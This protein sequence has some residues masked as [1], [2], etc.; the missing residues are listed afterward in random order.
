[1]KGI[2]PLHVYDKKRQRFVPVPAEHDQKNNR[3]VAKRN[4][5]SI[6]ALLV[7]T[8]P[9]EVTSIKASPSPFNPRIEV[10][11]FLLVAT[12]PSSFNVLI[13][14]KSGIVREL[15]TKPSHTG[16]ATVLWDGRDKD[17]RV[18]PDGEYTF[19]AKA[20]DMSG[21]ESSSVSGKVFVLMGQ[22]GSIKGRVRVVNQRDYSSVKVSVLGT[23]LEKETNSSGQFEIKGVPPGLHEAIAQRK[24]YFPEF[25]SNLSVSAGAVTS[26]PT[27]E[28]T[29]TA[30]T[31]GHV[32][33]AYVTPDDD[34]LDDE[35]VYN[36]KSDRAITLSAIIKDCTGSVVAKPW[37][38]RSVKPGEHNV[39]WDCRTF[40]GVVETNGRHEFTLLAKVGSSQ[41]LQS[42]ESFVVDEG[43][44]RSLF[45]TPKIISPNGDG[46]DDVT[47]IVYTVTSTAEVKLE[48]IDGSGSPL[49]QLVKNEK[50]E[51][52]DYSV[53]WQGDDF[54]GNTLAD[55]TYNVVLS[56]RYPDGH[57][58]KEFIKTV[59]IDSVVPEVRDLRPM[60]GTTLTTGMPEISARLVASPGDVPQGNVKIKVDEHTVLPDEYSIESGLIRYRPK[61]SLGSGTHIAIVY[62]RD[63]AGN[64]APP[65]A[66]SFKVEF[67]KT[68][69]DSVAPKVIFAKPDLDGLVYRNDPS[70]EL[71]IFDEQSGVDKDTIELYIDGER[72]A[73]SVV[74]YIPGK[75]GKAWD[76]WQYEKM[77]VLFDPLQGRIRYNS[78]HELKRRTELEGTHTWRF[79]IKDRAGNTSKE[80]HGRFKLKLD[81]EPP[82][83]EILLPRKVETIL[84]P[85]FSWELK[86]EGP[87]G[88]DPFNALLALDGRLIEKFTAIANYKISKELIG[89]TKEFRINNR[90][91]ELPGDNKEMRFTAEVGRD[92]VSLSTSLRSNDGKLVQTDIKEKYAVLDNRLKSV[93]TASCPNKGA[94]FT[95]S[96][97]KENLSIEKRFDEEEKKRC[98]LL[99]N[100]RL[101]SNKELYIEAFDEDGSLISK[102]E[103][104]FV[105]S[106]KLE[107]DLTNDEEHVIALAV[108]DRAGN[109]SDVFKKYFVTK[110]DEQRPTI[111][112]LSPR[113][114]QVV[115]EAPVIRAQFYDDGESGVD[116]DG[117]IL[118]LDGRRMTPV[119]DIDKG[120][121]TRE[122]GA[123]TVGE[124]I[125]T[126]TICDRA[127]N[128]TKKSATFYHSTDMA[129]PTVLTFTPPH[130]STISGSM[131]RISATVEDRGTGVDPSSIIVSLDG[132]ILAKERI[133]FD[134]K[135][136]HLSVNAPIKKKTGDK[137]IIGLALRD[138]GGN[139]LKDRAISVFT[140]MRGGGAQ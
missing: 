42:S 71:T 73:N 69:R 40:D 26:L 70:F 25:W 76:M 57:Q 112:Y 83:A 3:L 15:K 85:T 137:H 30:L 72:V 63:V 44:A 78:L 7:D 86:D 133:V 121:V 107:N 87:S 68:K 62:A 59:V 130:G 74:E 24:D 129:Q 111:V 66:V 77:K 99:L 33:S 124:H 4:G 94:Q 11:R 101:D 64:E 127:G 95:V 126:L 113:D 140:S 12:E 2:C 51:T 17:G 47:S 96:R 14:D 123:L 35:F 8:Q 103:P 13:K 29:N 61:T 122:L 80:H 108:F 9:P 20:V 136:G 88:G 37:T 67:D 100:G 109:K 18:L 49:Q 10:I 134:V 131:V 32:I 28:L 79:V 27:K 117:I 139:P 93:I 31:E 53:D 34:G 97:G 81:E 22:G 104:S 19:S 92:I 75:S 105:V 6:Y 60:N 125:V 118:T 106:H 135:T 120:E 16:E 38:D 116:K 36:F 54:L 98:R 46:L 48:V 128:R 1:M 41:L 43:L 58:S 39:V 21:K 65:Q 115:R 84:S 23:T 119:V 91:L 90:L 102:V 132:E 52:G 110:K 5:H 138:F 56:S 82:K 89:R 114:G 50:Q 55:G 45:V